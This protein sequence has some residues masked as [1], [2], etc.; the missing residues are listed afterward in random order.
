MDLTIK[1][2]EGLGDIR[3][4]MPITSVHSL[5]GE[6]NETESI[7]NAL[8]E[9]TT[10]LRYNEI[11]LTLFF[12]GNEPCLQCIDICHEDTMLFGKNIFNLTE[13]EITQLMVENNYLE[14]DIEAEDWGEKR[15]SFYE[16]NIDFYFNE[17]ELV[18]VSVGN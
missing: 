5:L 18:S 14:Q 9:P 4:S 10:I 17:G 12:E 13:Q 8:D 6:A 1:I 3:F 2:K 7:S 15:I 11:E 16:A